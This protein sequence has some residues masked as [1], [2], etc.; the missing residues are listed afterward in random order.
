MVVPP[1]THGSPPGRP[2]EG[3]GD[4]LGKKWLIVS[5]A[6]SDVR[7]KWL[8]ISSAACEAAPGCVVH[9]GE[10]RLPLGAEVVGLPFAEL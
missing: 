8:T 3:Y 7:K 4:G 9:Q 2:P 1:A 5:S 10:V 6:A